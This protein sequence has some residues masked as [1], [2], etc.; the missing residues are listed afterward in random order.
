MHYKTWCVVTVAEACVITFEASGVDMETVYFQGPVQGKGSYMIPP[1]LSPPCEDGGKDAMRSN[2]GHPDMSGTSPSGR[3]AK[4][5]GEIEWEITVTEASKITVEVTPAPSLDMKPVL[6]EGFSMDAGT[7]KVGL[8][9]I[10]PNRCDSRQVSTSKPH[11]RFPDRFMTLEECVWDFRAYGCEKR[12]WT[13]SKSVGTNASSANFKINVP[14]AG[15]YGVGLGSVVLHS[16]AEDGNMRDNVPESPLDPPDPTTYI[17]LA[18]RQ[19]DIRGECDSHSQG[20]HSPSDPLIL[21]GPTVPTFVGTAG[22]LSLLDTTKTCHSH[23][24]GRQE[25]TEDEGGPSSKKIRTADVV[26]SQS[27]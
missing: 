10:R 12:E 27:P 22:S 20:S 3:P 18:G 21:Q 24:R 5:L 1:G 26:G 9:P 17:R 14:G 25:P 2:P 6:F 13:I 23:K 19:N 4:I 7:L 15:R 16:S 8:K 11:H